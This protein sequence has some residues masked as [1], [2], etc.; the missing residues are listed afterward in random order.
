MVELLVVLTVL[1]VLFGVTGLALASL[2]VPRETESVAAMRRVRAEAI[3]AGE[4]RT[5]HG[6]LFLPDG[7]AIGPNVDLLTGIPHAR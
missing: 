7:R 2:T 5:S 6:V 1:G 4:R 3:Q